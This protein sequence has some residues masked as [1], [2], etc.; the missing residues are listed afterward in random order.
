[1]KILL[2]S[3][4]LLCF[5]IIPNV[6]AQ[7]IDTI[8]P[9]IKMPIGSLLAQFRDET[10]VDTSIQNVI[11]VDVTCKV[12]FPSEF[13]NIFPPVIKDETDPFP[14]IEVD[15][16]IDREHFKVTKT[17]TARDASGNT[18]KLVVIINSSKDYPLHLYDINI[19]DSILIIEPDPEVS[20]LFI[21]KDSIYFCNNDLLKFKINCEW[22][23]PRY[24][25]EFYW[26]IDGKYINV[27]IDT[28]LYLPLDSLPTTFNIS[29]VP[30]IFNNNFPDL[31][32]EINFTIRHLAHLKYQI[33]PP[34]CNGL[35]DGSIKILEGESVLWDNNSISPLREGIGFGKYWFLNGNDSC[36][37]VDTVSLTQ[38][39]ILSF[40]LSSELI[41]LNQQRTITITNNSTM[42]GPYSWNIDGKTFIN[43]DKTF[44]ISFAKSGLI[45]I[46]LSLADQRC[47][48]EYAK[49]LTVTGK[50]PSGEKT[51]FKVTNPT[52]MGAKDGSIKISG[53]TEI[54]WENMSGDTL[55][56]NLDFGKYWVN[57]RSGDSTYTD[58]L[59]LFEEKTLS[60]TV[61]NDS[62]DLNTQNLVEITNTS[63]F[64]GPYAWQIG[65]DTILNDNE[66]LEV[67]VKEPG[68]LIISLSLFESNCSDIYSKTI[69]IVGQIPTG[70][71]NS[72]WTQRIKVL[73]TIV[74]DYL[75]VYIPT[76]GNYSVGIF[77]LNGKLLYHNNIFES[78][79]NI[80][81]HTLSPGI[82]IIKI[83]DEIM[84]EFSQKFIKVN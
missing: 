62:I 64:D 10:F 75:R 5:S 78:N 21:K 40:N 43:N 69:K 83:K 71:L 6:K 17:W 70:D 34:T 55:R 58:T 16:L 22:E 76:E 28:V 67:I 54:V 60:F 79:S 15:T 39:K 18:S 49:T 9:V 1:M 53:A 2:L 74:N 57:Y 56:Q 36:S 77:D 68:N 8:P 19:N 73:P 20:S 25:K 82:Y 7:V 81:V 13:L 46:T 65:K 44:D 33:T 51:S 59:L 84:T 37:Y 38:E 11:K 24:K 45:P 3:V 29:V 66:H 63:T 27:D 52:C 42:E 47:T 12:L 26:K 23:C 14:H 4:L 61:F 41:D 30:N 32:K 80:P 72:A 48:D 35:K 50:I 31:G